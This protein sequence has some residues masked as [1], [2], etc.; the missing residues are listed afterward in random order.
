VS[1]GGRVVFTLTGSVKN[2]VAL[3]IAN[4][5]MVTPPAGTVDPNLA[6]N[7]SR[8]VVKRG[9]VPTRLKV[10]ITPPTATIRSGVPVKV[11]IVTSNVG[12]ATAH[13]V[14]TCLSLPKGITVSKAKGGFPLN[15]RYC[16]RAKAVKSGGKVTYNLEIRG[17]GR[18]AGRIQ[19]AA[20]ARASNA[21]RVADT[22]RLTVLSGRV[23]HRGGYTG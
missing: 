19:L 3:S 21:A 14:L 23:T 22:S 1:K 18:L 10:K 2:A 16:W 5:A 20:Q 7:T 4:T 17:D 15:G 9:V 8:V 13:K 11:K 6:N 12:G